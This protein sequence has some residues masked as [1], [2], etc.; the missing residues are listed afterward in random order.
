MQGAFC[1]PPLRAHPNGGDVA[2]LHQPIGCPGMNAQD[3]SHF[4]DGQQLGKN[5]SHIMLLGVHVY[6]KTPMYSAMHRLS[7][8]VNNCHSKSLKHRKTKAGSKEQKALRMARFPGGAKSPYSRSKDNNKM[9]EQVL[10]CSLLCI[11]TGRKHAQT[12]Q[13]WRPELP[14]NRHAAQ[15]RNPSPNDPPGRPTS[16]IDSCACPAPTSNTPAVGR[17]HRKPAL[18]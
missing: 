12:S 11:Y 5:S 14:G 4:S 10:L 7:K 16:R 17:E 2:V 13:R 15:A 9:G 1:D 8:N 3:V 6:H 18:P